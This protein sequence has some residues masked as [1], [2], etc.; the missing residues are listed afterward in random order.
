MP[1]QISL[2]FIVI[3]D[4]WTPWRRYIQAETLLRLVLWN[5]ALFE[6]ENYNVSI[7]SPLNV[8]YRRPPRNIRY[9]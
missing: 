4:E 9:A 1:T 8:S 5:E 3:I 2:N 6:Q 7:F